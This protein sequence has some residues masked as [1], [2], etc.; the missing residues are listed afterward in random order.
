MA[1]QIKEAA[2]GGLFSS[3]PKS[4]MRIY[5][6]ISTQR[7]RVD[8][9]RVTAGVGV[10]C[11]PGIAFDMLLQNEDMPM[12]RCDHSRRRRCSRKPQPIG[13]EVQLRHDMTEHAKRGSATAEGMRTT[14]RTTADGL[15]ACFR[16]FT[17]ISEI[18]LRTALHAVRFLAVRVL[19]VSVEGNA[20]CLRIGKVARHCDIAA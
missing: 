15:T 20:R 1:G 7:S 13:R 14:G 5:D 11:H 4:R 3:Q 12:P 2:L 10:V 9:G 8:P 16:H 17:R 19:G 18:A 6:G